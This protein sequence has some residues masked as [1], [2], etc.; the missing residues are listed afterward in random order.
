MRSFAD[1][2]GDRVGDL[3]GLTQKL[4]YLNDGDPATAGDLG[5]GAVWLM[6]IFPSPS[7]HGYDVTDYR[8]VNPVY[9]TLADFDAFVAA[10][11]RRGIRVI[12]DMV[13]NHSSSQH[14]WF[15]LS[16]N[17]SDAKRTWYSWRDAAPTSGWLQPWAGGGRA[18]WPLDGA[19]YWG[20]FGSGMPD[21][22]L[23]SPAVEAEMLDVLR[24]W[25]ARGVDGFRLDAVR[26]FFES[27][28]GVVVDQPET[29][30]FLRRLRSA[31]SP[32]YPGVLLVAEAW[33][34]LETV[35]SY[36]GAGDETQLAFAFDLADAVKGGVLASDASP[37]INTIARTETALAGKDRGF[38]A[39]FLSNHDQVRVMRT[40]GGDAAGARLAAATLFALPGTPFVYYGEE[41]GMQ[42]GAPS[43]DQNKRTP[44]RWNATP[45]GFGF[46]TDAGWFYAAE[47]DGVD[48]ASQ[49]A[50]PASLWHL[51]RRLVS[52]RSGQASLA[53]GEPVRP[54]VTGGGAGVM[55]L[56]RG[57]AGR[58]TLFVANYGSAASGPFT[59]DV[60][61]APAVLLA[62]GLGGT[63]T[64]AGGKVTIPDL[65]ARAFAFLSID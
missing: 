6:P 30:A 13:V 19:Y 3:A 65:A 39:P 27:A 25:L 14:P 7:Y 15:A 12:L 5:V 8:S 45:P 31:L 24:F 61:G 42:G 2:N 46:S 54:V 22:N 49:Q 63:P 35:S 16:R 60:T 26:H 58:R 51:Y 44:L 36:Y 55:A 29:H 64:S 53:T 32:E 38:D 34:N 48:I 21:L 1:S 20:L 4:D 17:P 41:I 62:E 59:V 47:A 18:W 40:L 52:L 57:S 11:H 37:V 43:A 33:T 10:A 56:L 23:A 50:D 9:G 28:D